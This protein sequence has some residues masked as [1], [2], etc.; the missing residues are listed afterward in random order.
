MLAAAALALAGGCTALPDESNVA[1]VDATRP[2]IRHS[3]DGATAF[4]EIDVLTYNIE[5]LPF[6]ARNNRGP[7]LREIAHRLAEFRATGEGPDIIVFQEVFSKDAAQAVMD[8]GYRSIVTGPRRGSEQAPNTQGALP[9]SRNIFRGEIGPN[10]TSAGLAI[11]SDYPVMG[12][13][14]TPYARQSCAGFDCLSNKGVLFAELAIPGV[15]GVVDVFT[16]HM[17]SQ[18]ASRVAE[19]RHAEAHR[20]Q[21]YELAD[22]IRASSPLTDPI[23]IGGDFNMRNS[24]VRH[25]TF[26]RITPDSHPTAEQAAPLGNVHRYCSE[27]RDTCDVRQDWAEDQWFRVQNLHLFQSGTVV[28]VR[29]I[30]VEG[31]FD[32]GPSGPV[33]SDHNGFRVVYRLSWPASETTPSPTC[34]YTPV[35]SAL[36]R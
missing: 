30:R 23:L 14:Y 3:A 28:T 5:G 13:G 29:P 32:G 31:M 4:T 24:D 33:L 34:P 6:P 18:R 1:C 35:A 2:W 8:A 20:R 27:H 26:D 22:F 11:A 16:T 15:P 10:F 19:D 12:A 21:M 25:T 9:G 7:A 17:Q 36:A